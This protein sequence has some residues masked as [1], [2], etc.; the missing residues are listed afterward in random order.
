MA[1]DV[2]EITMP[3]LGETV[4]EGTLSRWLKAAGDTVAFDDP[5]FEVST[6]K[7]DS[8]IPSPYDGVL[9]EILVGEG[10]TV[11]VGTALARI[12]EPG[13]AAQGGAGPAAPAEAA[14]A[15]PSA[16]ATP[17][18]A[19]APAPAAPAPASGGGN[20]GGQVLSPVVRRLVAENNLDISRL[21][22]SGAGGRIMREDVIAAIASGTATAAAPAQAASAQ[23][24][25]AQAAPAQA[26]P[27][28]PPP[29]AAAAPA[30][31]QAVPAA[32][33]TA[34]EREE[35][36]P[37]SRI[38]LI[39]AERMVESKRI[40]PHVWTS[41]EVDLEAVEQVRAR[42]KAAFRKAEGA[43]LTY[44]PFI[45]R[46][47][48]DGLRA[49]PTMNSSLDMAS[50]TM[51]LHHFVNLAIAVDVNEQGLMAPVIFDAD[52][53][54]LRGMARAIK[55]VG[56]AAKNKTLKANEMS[57]STF[58]I[59]NPGPLGT[60]ASAAIINQ[61]NVGIITT[62]GVARRVVAIGDDAIAI[63]HTCVLGLSYDH[64]ALDGVTAARFL[65]YIRDALQQRDWEAE[66]A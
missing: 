8:E 3:K 46:V 48:C 17:A 42:H 2:N 55:R 15:A 19:G 21:T 64:R 31:A 39:T 66:L 25:P 38:R 35:V 34:G 18:A 4:T 32:Q 57:G 24:V 5:L 1:D 52:T 63:H 10:Q 61:P 53:L 6:D 23:A 12:G 41:I 49:F 44:L 9:L 43:S 59:S 50:K 36:V 14:A 56:D 62:E 45:A 60:Y 27:A 26:A 47:I 13:G 58:T 54:N 51:K 33:P 11:P 16:P 7:V 40:S 20:G 30:K 29:A 37:L 28:A 65:G 22:G